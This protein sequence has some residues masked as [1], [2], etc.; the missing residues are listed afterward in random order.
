M[1][2]QKARHL[3]R[4]LGSETPLSRIGAK[5]VDGY[6]A[7]RLE[8]GAARSTIHKELST[9]RGTLRLAKRR[10]EFPADI[11]QVMP[12]DFAAQYKPKKRAL[13]F[14]EAS[15]LLAALAPKRAALVCFLLATGATYPSEVVNFR[16]SDADTKR[17]LVHLRGTKRET[18]DRR[19]PVVAFARGW[20]EQA[21]PF[22]P[23]ERWSNIRR[24]LHAACDEAQIARC[25]PND[26]RRTLATL[27][28]AHGVE[29]HLIGNVLGHADSR[30]VERVY[31]RLAPEQ[32]ASLLEA[33]IGVPQWYKQPKNLAKARRNA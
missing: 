9:L 26:L 10:G 1:L 8:E 24:D 13:S 27:L 17:W 32:L 14:A 4:L 20:L 11:D 7:T 31:G 22:A 33:R 29:P 5:E 2:T 23:F 25:S 28:R 18:R 19:V 3:N 16:R 21:L 6:V 15:K 30:M 12:I